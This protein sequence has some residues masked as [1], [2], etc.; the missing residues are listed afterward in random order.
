MSDATESDRPTY[1]KPVINHVGQCT[2]DLDLATRF[3]CELLG[4]E[5]ERDLTVPD[6][7]VGPLLGVEPP[8]GL[9]ACTSVVVA[10]PSSSCISTGRATRAGPNGGSTNRGSPIC[11][12]RWST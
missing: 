7:A 11:R 4:F 12:C 8:V 2:T 10:S 1:D 3:Y 9:R 5:I 6:E